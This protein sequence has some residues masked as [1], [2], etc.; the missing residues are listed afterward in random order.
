M[1]DEMRALVRIKAAAH[2]RFVTCASAL[3]YAPT[4]PVSKRDK[5]AQCATTT[6]RCVCVAILNAALLFQ[7]S[8]MFGFADRH[9]IDIFV[10]VL[11]AYFNADAHVKNR[12]CAAAFMGGMLY[13]QF[14][15]EL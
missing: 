2:L 7:I 15:S 3:T 13:Q 5:N 1:D 9:T 8:N 11:G 4:T 6:W 14:A 12:R 10:R